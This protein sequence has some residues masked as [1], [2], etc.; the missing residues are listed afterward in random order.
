MVK[1][2]KQGQHRSPFLCTF[3]RNRIHYSPRTGTQHLHIHSV[4]G[5]VGWGEQWFPESLHW[6]WFKPSAVGPLSM[7]A[8]LFCHRPF[9]A[10]WKP[11]PLPA[12]PS[13]PGDGLEST[14]FTFPVLPKRVTKDSWVSLD[15]THWSKGA[16][17]WQVMSPRCL[18]SHYYSCC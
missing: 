6:P 4:G 7:E 16:T 10:D 2:L 1:I 17:W 11:P 15:S 3:K 14:H 12:G 18:V 8:F 9:A 5:R 13:G